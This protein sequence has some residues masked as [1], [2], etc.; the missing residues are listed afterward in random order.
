MVSEIDTIFNW[1]NPP[2]VYRHIQILDIDVL[3][4]FNYVSMYVTTRHRCTQI[5]Q[6]RIDVPKYLSLTYSNTRHV[7]G[8]K[9]LTCPV[10][11]TRGLSRVLPILRSSIRT[12][13][14]RSIC[15]AL[16]CRYSAETQPMRV[17]DC[18]R[19]DYIMAERNRNSTAQRVWH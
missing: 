12:P 16:L 11:S 2:T 9:Y 18:C 19:W 14:T 5:L 4:Y 1:I 8:P 15:P 7:N 6:Q 10:S 3:R 13:S 17:T